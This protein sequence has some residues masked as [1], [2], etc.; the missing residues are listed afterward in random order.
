MSGNVFEWVAD[1]YHET[2]VGA[3][4][5]GSVWQ[6]DEEKRV[7]RGGS[8]YYFPLFERSSARI[9]VK[10]TYRVAIK[11]LGLRLAQTLP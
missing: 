1:S 3:P 2:Y 11:D 4:T 8:W 9:W 6:G 10:P 5:D 7:V